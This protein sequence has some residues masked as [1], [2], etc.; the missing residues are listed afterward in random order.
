MWGVSGRFGH[1]R[2]NIR[3]IFPL[4][5]RMLVAPDLCEK[6]NPYIAAITS[7]PWSTPTLSLL[8][9]VIHSGWN[10]MQSLHARVFVDLQHEA[11][12]EHLHP[13]KRR[14]HEAQNL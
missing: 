10:D 13:M 1:T 12:N 4:G 14:K 5:T 11:P 7:T 2:G 3:V 8:T 6:S 9:L